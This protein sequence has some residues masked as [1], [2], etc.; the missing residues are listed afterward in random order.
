MT[1][2]ENESAAGN[3]SREGGL[4]HGTAECAPR[5]T[6]RGP[7]AAGR[8]PTAAGR[9]PFP[10]KVVLAVFVATRLA[11]FLTAAVTVNRVMP[12]PDMTRNFI[13]PGVHG[14]ILLDAFSRW[15]SEWYLLIA[16]HG[17][18]CADVY[19]QGPLYEAGDTAGFFPLYPLCVR[20]AAAVTG[21]F[22][23]AGVIVSNAFFLAA[24]FLLA[25]LVRLDHSNKAAVL[26][27]LFIS[28]FPGAVFFAAVY[29]ESLF[30]FL[31]L[32]VIYSSRRGWWWALL[33]LGFC[34]ALA[35][36]VGLLL[37]LPAAWELL[38]SRRF[39][40]SWNLAWLAGFPAGIAAFA[41]FC[42]HV[43]G[44]PLAFAA[45][46]TAWRGTMSGPWKAFVRFFDAPAFHGS[47]NSG[48]DFAV[49]VLAIA[50]TIW[51]ARKLRPSCT[52][53][54]A[55]LVL[56]PLCTTLWSFT[57]L[58]AVVFPLFVGLALVAEERPAVRYAY[59]ALAPVLMGLYMVLFASW[60]WAA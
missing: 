48:V 33:P 1:Q 14:E 20:A 36:P 40:P 23:L 25:A 47:H 6:S 60:S 31:A 50:G 15:D 49:A 39:K 16:K 10:W 27:V 35:R 59:L 41:I 3:G 18:D 52:L 7:T 26:A 45:R 8:S 12:S 58:A 38:R 11:L 44:S 28:V 4:A 56:V 32:A 55:C 43:F 34:A 42:A 29:S 19:A 53:L 21:D 46:Q 22:V 2:H 37:L 24:L 51:F 30:L 13:C 57:R 54:S 9:S 5:G 17:Y